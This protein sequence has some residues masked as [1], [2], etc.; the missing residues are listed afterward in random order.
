MAIFSQ[1]NN[2]TSIDFRRYDEERPNHSVPFN[3]PAD[4]KQKLR[5]FMREIDL[6]SG[7]IDMIYNNNGNYCFLEV[8]PVGQFGMISFPC[9]YKIEKKI[10][11]ILIQ[12]YAN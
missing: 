12:Q 10:A 1:R 5:R 9:N 11:E 2:R 3:L 6:D 4:I 8:N 7:A